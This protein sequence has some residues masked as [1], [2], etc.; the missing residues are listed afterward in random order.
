MRLG[1]AL[2]LLAGLVGG[3]GSAQ[4]QGIFTCI[5]GRGHKITADRPIAD[6]SDREQ[7]ELS[8]SG[9][10]MRKLGPTLT[11]KERA[12]QEARDMA[13]AEHQARLHD[14]KRRERALMLR[15]PNPAAHQRERSAALALV[16]EVIASSQKRSVELVAERKAIATQME[17]YAKDP[18]KAPMALKSRSEGN[19]ANMRAQQ[20]FVASQVLEKQ[21]IN[22]R[23]D[24]ELQALQALWARNSVPR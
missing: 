19:D 4:A 3:V 24:E 1:C 8:K 23:F 17:F 21:R 12:V 14:E 2:M 13:E 7:H 16:D 6:C 20:A 5:D 15:Y 22:Q 11:A 18:T 10:V 9:T